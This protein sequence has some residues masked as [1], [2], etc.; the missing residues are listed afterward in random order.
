[1]VLGTDDP[2]FAGT[3]LKT[4][5]V[6]KAERI[7]VVARTIVVRRLGPLSGHHMEAVRQAVKLA[8]LID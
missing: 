8:L 4:T 3:G 7:A 5:S 1:M 2:A 6:V